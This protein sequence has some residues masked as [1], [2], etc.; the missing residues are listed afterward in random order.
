MHDEPKSALKQA[1]LRS[2]AVLRELVGRFSE[3]CLAWGK[4]SDGQWQGEY[5][6]RPNMVQVYAAADKQLDQAAA[7]FASLFCVQYPEYDGMVGLA[8]F[9]SHRIGHN[10]T[11][12]LRHAIGL[13]WHRHGTFDCDEAS[14]DAIVEEFA[15]FVDRPTVPLRLLGE[16]L[17]R[18]NPVYT[19]LTNLHAA[20]IVNARSIQGRCITAGLRIAGGVDHAGLLIDVDYH[21]VSN[22]AGSFGHFVSPLRELFSDLF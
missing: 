5:Q 10:N 12:I 3:P 13:T 2:L 9:G 4:R 20:G 17:R 21:R 22:G 16:H 18:N 11:H 15:D 1:I 6:Q 19:L 8:G 14:V 7:E